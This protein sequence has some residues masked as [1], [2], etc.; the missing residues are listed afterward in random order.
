MGDEH[1][2][3]RFIFEVNDMVTR[4]QYYTDTSYETEGLPFKT[5]DEYERHYYITGQSELHSMWLMVSDL[6]DALTVSAQLQ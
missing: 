2:Q 3:L 4:D 5:L 6:E 1:V